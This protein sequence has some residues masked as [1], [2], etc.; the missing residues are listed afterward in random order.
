MPIYTDEEKIS[1]LTDAKLQIDKLDGA[2][3]GSML[4]YYQGRAIGYLKALQKQSAI[5]SAELNSLTLIATEK[6]EKRKVELKTS[7]LLTTPIQA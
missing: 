4:A 7:G 5:T 1:A 2:E 3:N 6:S